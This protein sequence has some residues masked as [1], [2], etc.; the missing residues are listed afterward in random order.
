MLYLPFWTLVLGMVLSVGRH[1]INRVLDTY[2]FPLK[3]SGILLGDSEI[4]PEILSH[5]VE[6]ESRDILTRNVLGDK[7]LWL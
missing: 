1:Y 4:K 6:T 3:F 5:E 7:Y 2:N